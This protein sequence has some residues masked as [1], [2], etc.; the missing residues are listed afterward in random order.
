MKEYDFFISY[1][2]A[3]YKVEA[4]QMLDIVKQRGYSAWID[5]EHPFE[6]D[7]EIPSDLTDKRL[8]EHLRKGMESCKYVLFFETY[9]QLVM[10]MN[11][12]CEREKGWQEHELDMAEAERV[13]VFY[14]SLKPPVLTFGQ[15]RNVFEY[16]NLDGAFDL[17]VKGLEDPDTYFRND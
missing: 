9:A 3:K 11:G 1:K 14:Q 10:V 15:N 5:K 12:P 17:V 16:T 8:A 6:V 13:I 2:W 7:P 4:I